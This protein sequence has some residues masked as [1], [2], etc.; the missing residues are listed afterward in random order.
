V[1]TNKIQHLLD[2]KQELSEHEL[3]RSLRDADTLLQELEAGRDSSQYIVHVDCDAFY[4]AVEEL[5]RPEL[6]DVPFAVGGGVLTTCNYHAR[7]FGCRSGMAGFV[8]KKL[9][10]QLVLIPISFAKYNAKAA[11]VRE[12]IA[13]YD[14]RFQ[15]A[16]CDEAYLNI[17][18]YCAEKDM[19]PAEAVEQMRREIYENAKITVSAGIGPNA[20]VAKICSNMNK[21]N[22]QHM[23]PN[24]RAEVLRFMRD[25]PVRKVNGVGR[26]FERE[27]AAVG[28]KTCGDVFTE[29]QYLLPLFGEKAYNFLLHCYLGLGSTDI[30]PAE[31]YERKSVGTESTFGEMSD[32]ERLRAKLQK[33]AEELETDLAKAEVKGRTLVLKVK[34][35]TFE[36]FTR[37]VVTPK[38]V[39]KADDIYSFALPMLAKLEQDRGGLRL[40]LMGLRCTHLVSTRRP[41]TMAFFGFRSRG[42]DDTAAARRRIEVDEDGWEK[43]PEELLEAELEAGYE[44]GHKVDLAPTDDGLMRGS[45]DDVGFRRHGKEIVPNPRKKVEDEEGLWDCPICGRP[46]AA[47]ESSFN[48]H[49][50]HCLSRR[51]IKDVVQ[52]LQ[53][54]DSSSRPSEKR[55]SSEEKKPTEKKRGKPPPV[56]PRQKKLRFG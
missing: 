50:D 25:L 51:T 2:R 9:C 35:H 29:R 7:K 11:E 34:L 33:T 5:D 19:G 3:N 20:R 15:S 6:K 38:L 37:Q 30:K 31:E 22:G 27:L 32:P 49:I 48:E 36:V 8:A 44:V 52:E 23:V 42:G 17:T 47:E 18:E 14:A 16:S 24:D 39:S 13:R 45:N 43:L 53:G 26:V 28:I 10:P 1:L 41:D 46:Q 56:D 21:P 4:A 54:H 55:P 40:R 12:V